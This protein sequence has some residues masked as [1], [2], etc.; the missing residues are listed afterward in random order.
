MS[1]IADRLRGKTLLVTGAT[2]FLAKAM[3]AKIVRDL[4][5]VE[6]IVLLLRERRR[7]G[8]G[9]VRAT[10]RLECEVLGSS[11]F[12][13]L[14]SELGDAFD[15][16]VRAKVVA[17]E[18][19]L[20]RDGLGLSPDDARIVAAVDVIVN[21][22]ATVVFDER[23]DIALAINTLGARRLL[24]LS[25]QLGGAPLIHVS[26]AYACGR[27]SGLVEEELPSLT[28]AV[29]DDLAG[30]AIGTLD[31]DR[32]IADIEATCERLEERSVTPELEA[33]LA[34]TSARNGRGLARNG[35]VSDEARRR[36]LKDALVE[37]GMARARERGWNDTYTYTKSLGERVL[38]AERGDVPACIVRPA[39]IESSMREP[40]PGWIDGLRMA[41]PIFAAFGKGTVRRMPSDPDA[42]IDFI[43]V[44]HVVNAVLAATARLI[45]DAAAGRRDVRVY[46]VATSASNPLPFG[47]LVELSRDYFREKPFRDRKGRPIR[48]SD[49]LTISDEAFARSMR[50]RMALVGLGLSAL[51]RLPRTMAKGPRTELAR[52]RAQLE[53]LA[54]YVRIY[55]P[56]TRFPATF[57]TGRLDGLR[58][59][60]AREDRER[61]DFDV[62]AIDWPTYVQ[63]IHL[64]GLVR[65]VLREGMPGP[66]AHSAA[67]G[68]E[69]FVDGTGRTVL[70]LL[71]D[72]AAAHGNR[73]AVQVHRGRTF[74]HDELF[75]RALGTAAALRSAGVGPGDRVVLQSENRP[76]WSMA[77][78]GIQAAGA[79][80]VPLD[81][82]LPGRRV[83]EVARFVGAR[84]IVASDKTRAALG[85]GDPGILSL[86]EITAHGMDA[87]SA[88]RQGLPVAVSPEQPASILFTSGTTLD[89]KGVV[90]PHRSFLANVRS[91]RD[92]LAPTPDDR[93]VSVLPLHHAFEF[94]AGLLAPLSAG[95]SIT[96]LE[97]INAQVIVEA[98]RDTKATVLIGVPRLY[99]LMLEGIRRQMAELPGRAGAALGALRGTSR[100]FSAVGLGGAGKALLS[101]IHAKF[102]GAVRAFISGG[103]ALD[104]RVFEGFTALGFTLVEGYGLTECAPVV[105]INPPSAP[106]AGSVGKVVP[107]VEARIHLA[108]AG[109]VGEIVVRGPS[110]MAGYYKDPAATARVIRDGW[111]HTGDLGRLDEQGY[112][113]VTGRLKDMIVTASGKN[114]YPDEVEAAL[115][116]LPGVKESCV[117]GVHPREGAGEEVH[118]VVV[119][120]DETVAVGGIE[121]AHAAIRAAVAQRM[122]DQPSH[123]RVQR[124][125]FW[126]EDLPK[127]ALMKVKRGQV[128][129]RLEGE[130][131]VAAARRDQADGGAPDPLAREI[132]ALL[133]RLTRTAPGTI[134]PDQNLAF[135]LAVDS[136]MLAE[137][138]AAIEART[139]GKADVEGAKDL[140]TV[141]DLLSLATRLKPPERDEPRARRG[142]GRMHAPAGL[143]ARTAAP[144][145]RTTWP[146][147]YEQYLALEVEGREHLPVAG[148]Y[149][150][151]A[152]H[153]SHLD[154]GAVLTAIGPGARRLHVVA[155]QDYFFDKAWKGA[156]FTEL[157]NAI[158]FDRHGDFT[159]GL[160][161]CRVALGSGNPLLIFPEGTRSVD[162]RLQPFK[163]GLGML[164]LEMGVPIV[165]ARIDGTHAVLPKGARIPRRHPI[166]VAFG[167]PLDALALAPDDGALA[168]ERYR[169]V[170]EG[171]RQ[172]IVELGTHAVHAP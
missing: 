90:L 48:T 79:V 133:A 171:V 151:A 36:W 144:L 66:M 108:G 55:G 58:Q 74:T 118:L 114:V 84:G 120:A 155:A 44:D 106:R 105:T 160:A 102:G 158:P 1:S 11:A 40:E 47:R 163:A 99:D 132:V 23:L 134:H 168:Y 30:A 53:R 51:E 46:H 115:K 72:S 19:D 119:P 6:R 64:P 100:A 24:A 49:A 13:Q 89:P 71:A 166:R 2:G 96:Y 153:Q 56:Y 147:L 42:P 60:L 94:T 18:G 159:E 14:R 150:L 22:A 129:A 38:V 68:E 50:R 43:P 104:P 143:F 157:L 122:E 167:A 31:L 92:V 125:H 113:H 33:E 139:G 98:M 128:K 112:V 65:N 59:W 4:P 141:R 78:F 131:P 142:N 82:Q 124:I 37:A 5:E 136:L 21:S 28:R 41:D 101:P 162:G 86:E 54:Y 80:A 67:G 87:E 152:N 20:T 169:L 35:R 123:Q 148:A 103:A 88:G 164:A 3:V 25:R 10:E 170:A 12:R 154:A 109:G 27:R 8:G 26:T 73:L 76:E 126:E 156:F 107:G 93:L 138:V 140:V 81:A 95:G 110:V 83:R 52:A 161:A 45:E 137:L 97:Q 7:G 77:W 172:R 146:L 127:T 29:A 121:T 130:D 75:R 135:D 16:V 61:F 117:V 149:I 15:P 9:V 111:F 91:I 63:D 116:E 145:V 34:A 17:V 85:D 70:S 165:P 57:A 39:I 62:R 32:E 69:A